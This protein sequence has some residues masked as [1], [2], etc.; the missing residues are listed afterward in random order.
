MRPG[1]K[2]KVVVGGRDLRAPSE[3]V[4]RDQLAH[5]AAKTFWRRVAPEMIELGLLTA[6]DVPA[7]LLMCEHFAVARE[8]AKTV[9][10]AGLTRKDEAG[11][12]RKHPLLQ[13]MRDNSKAFR[14]YAAEFGMT[15]SSRQRLAFEAP[16]E[17]DELVQLLF[18]HV[19]EPEDRR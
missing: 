14:M 1:P 18:R 13:I 10:R 12:E 16:E 2:P 5:E 17:G 3:R 19:L 15:P 9:A 6:V 11:V 4:P 7:F 8:A